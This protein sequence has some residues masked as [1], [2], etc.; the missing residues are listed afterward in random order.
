MRCSR[1]QG[2]ATRLVYSGQRPAES[3]FVNIIINQPVQA[4]EV[5]D[6]QSI[7]DEGAERTACDP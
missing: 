1:I 6:A 5:L 2:N 3:V 7:Q 4:Q